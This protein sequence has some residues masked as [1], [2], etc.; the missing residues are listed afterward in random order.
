MNSQKLNSNQ[1]G[2]L[3]SVERTFVAE[4]HLF[5][6]ELAAIDPRSATEHDLWYRKVLERLIA[7]HSKFIANVFHHSG[8]TRYA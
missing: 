5:E 3:K 8:T 1:S 7:H 6:R 4:L 2:S